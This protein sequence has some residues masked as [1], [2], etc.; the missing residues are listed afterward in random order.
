VEL[1]VERNVVRYKEQWPNMIKKLLWEAPQ[2]QLVYLESE[3][4]CLIVE[5][6]ELND[7]VEDCL[8]DE[9]E[10]STTSVSIH[11]EKG[12]G[13]Y[14]NYFDPEITVQRIIESLKQIDL[15]EVERI[16]KLNN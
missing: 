10:F 8:W 13:I 3:E 4:L 2:I 1:T 16:Y 9:F 5:D 14:Y 12:I 11:E 15:N 7:F 6:T